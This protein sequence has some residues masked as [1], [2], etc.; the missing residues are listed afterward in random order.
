MED[1]EAEKL[2]PI[3]FFLCYNNKGTAYENDRKYNMDS[4]RGLDDSH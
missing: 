2:Q 4:V 3:R 1:I